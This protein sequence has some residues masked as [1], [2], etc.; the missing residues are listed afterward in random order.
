MFPL[1]FCQDVKTISSNCEVKY[2]IG[3]ENIFPLKCHK[4]LGDKMNLRVSLGLRNFVIFYK[5]FIMLLSQVPTLFR[6]NRKNTKCVRNGFSAVNSS[7]KIMYC[8][9]YKTNCTV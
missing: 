8:F 5:I 1:S 3:L 7:F 6:S 4:L 9:D 2:T